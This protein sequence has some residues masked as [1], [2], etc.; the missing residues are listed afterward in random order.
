MPKGRKPLSPRSLS[1][2][3]PSPESPS[4]E[5][6]NSQTAS[7]T[8]PPPERDVCRVCKIGRHSPLR[9]M[10][11]DGETGMTKVC[12]IHPNQA[13]HGL[14][15]CYELLVYLTSRDLRETLFH[16]MGPDRRGMPPI[17]TK[18]IDVN[19]L[20]HYHAANFDLV[21]WSVDHSVAQWRDKGQMLIEHLQY[22]YRPDLPRDCAEN[23]RQKIS[24][25]QTVDGQH[26]THG[27]LDSLVAHLKT[28]G[29]LL[30]SVE[31]F[32]KAQKNL[33]RC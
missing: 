28:Q 16:R 22:S 26:P 8:V 18:L 4:P 33:L 11:T 7:Q 21:P 27:D 1:L 5:R 9:C 3:S 24:S 12:P 25:F 31:A 32:V 2:E 13:D 29:S 14:D 20:A 17:Y 15:D 19:E 30:G 10:L 23:D 6:R